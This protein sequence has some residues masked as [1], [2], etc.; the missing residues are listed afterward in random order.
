MRR[1][2]P[3]HGQRIAFALLSLSAALVVLPVAGIL[4]VIVV[5]GAP[6][7][8]WV[9]L[10]AG[11]TKHMTEGGIL[12][13]IVGTLCLVLG[14]VVF[15]VPLGVMASIYLCEYARES[16]LT[17]AIRLAIV[18]LAGVPSVV[19]GLFGFG[20]FVI[21]FRFT[22]SILAGSLTLAIMNLPVIITATNEALKAVPQS[23]REVSLA[24]GASR[25]QTVRHVVLPNAIPGI[26][27]GVILEVSRAAGETAPILFTAAAAFAPMLPT[28]VFD[29]VMA[30]PTH[31]FH[32]AMESS[33]ADESLSFGVALVLL[34]LV[35]GVNAF[36]IVIRTRLRRRRRW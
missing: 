27:T 5:K 13:A 31:L 34:I 4:G 11:P 10:T 33:V 6:R 23:F 29:E 12:P 16:K 25:W 19:Y 28:S 18:N 17:Q 26:L 15:A 24:L 36:A 9:F 21:A 22:E 30:L 14:A 8:S 7:L 20:A 3:K 35:L 32:L 1:L 2:D